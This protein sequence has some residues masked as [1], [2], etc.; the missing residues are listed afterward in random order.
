MLD[1]CCAFSMDAMRRGDSV[2]FRLCDVSSSSFTVICSCFS[3][4]GWIP[5]GEKFRGSEGFVTHAVPVHGDSV[6]FRFVSKMK[7]D[8]D[9]KRAEFAAEVSGTIGS[10]MCSI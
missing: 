7:Y 1:A 5:I 4:Q 3:K 10:G 8:K 2:L 9:E 6:L